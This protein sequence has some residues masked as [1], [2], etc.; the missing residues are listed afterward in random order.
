MGGKF[1]TDHVQKQLKGEKNV[2]L[3]IFCYLPWEYPNFIEATKTSRKNLE[4]QEIVLPDWLQ[5][6]GCLFG[7]TT[8]KTSL[9][10]F[11]YNIVKTAAADALPFPFLL[12]FVA[13]FASIFYG[14]SLVSGGEKRVQETLEGRGRKDEQKSF[15]FPLKL[16]KMDKGDSF[17]ALSLI[18]LKKKMDCFLFFWENRVRSG[19]H[20]HLFAHTCPHLPSPQI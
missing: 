19:L 9:F 5:G 11:P 2:L 3:E 6:R 10:P 12:F 13:F 14:L 8:D 20:L 7:C 17:R 4:S 18:S 1:H 15:V 16:P